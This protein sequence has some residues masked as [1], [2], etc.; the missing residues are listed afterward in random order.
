MI[1]DHIRGDQQWKG[2]AKEAA[3]AV[4]DWAFRN[5]EH[6]ALYSYCKST[7][8]PSI[9]TVESIGMRFDREYPDEV[10]QVMH[11][12]VIDRKTWMEKVSKLTL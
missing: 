5:T 10:N 9:W 7:N 3:K 1:T 6:Q 12:S 11:V 2:Y 4:R 8:I